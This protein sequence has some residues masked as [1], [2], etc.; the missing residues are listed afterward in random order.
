MASALNA[1]MQISNAKG[2]SKQGDGSGGDGNYKDWIEIQSWE[3]DVEAETSWTKGGGASVGKPS[4]GKMSWEHYWDRS[5]ATLLLYICTGASFETIKLEMAKTTGA[6]K[7]Q[8]FFKVVM[9]DAFITKVTQSAT[10]EGNVVQKVEMVFK[11]ITIEYFQQGQNDK[12][13]GSLKQATRFWW[14]IP[15]GKAKS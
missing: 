2:E 13:P 10:D 6:G 14:D 8:A 1:F 5:S 7:P 15:G 4:P 11:E 12:N 9:N 3:W